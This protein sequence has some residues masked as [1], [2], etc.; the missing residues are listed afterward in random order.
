MI[1]CTSFIGIPL[2]TQS[3]RRRLVLGYYALLA[4]FFVPLFVLGKPILFTLIAQT[5]TLGGILGGI[6]AGGPV[7][8]YGSGNADPDAS[9]L[10]T[11]N[12]GGKRR[13]LC[14]WLD[15]REQSERD[16]AHYLAYKILRWVL[17]MTAVAYLVAVQF[18][19]A[20]LEP[21]APALLWMLLVVVLGLPQS[22]IL[23]NEAPLETEYETN[24]NTAATL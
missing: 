18:S 7:K 15:E 19:K 23:W 17:G 11:L 6:R 20:W 1:E 16:H 21:R 5:L 2:R 4:I 12:L 9:S 22:V 13:E 14:R 8:F 3:Q 24:L 10:L